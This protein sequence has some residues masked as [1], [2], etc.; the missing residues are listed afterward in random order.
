MMWRFLAR[1]CSEK[2]RMRIVRNFLTMIASKREDKT[3]QICVTL[4]D[5]LDPNVKKVVVEESCFTSK[6]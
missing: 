3:I 6:L 4:Y 5:K 1:L 2:L